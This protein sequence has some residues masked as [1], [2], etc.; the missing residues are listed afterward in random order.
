MSYNNNMIIRHEKP[1]DID[2]ITKVAKVAF[3]DHPFRQQT[4]HFIIRD[5]RA[6]DALAISLVTEK[7]RASWKE[8]SLSQP[9]IEIRQGLN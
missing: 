8:S 9:I 7:Q 6:A 1:S 4:E 2:T 3:R 5:L